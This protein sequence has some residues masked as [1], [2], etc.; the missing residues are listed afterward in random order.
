MD[1]ENDFQTRP[2]KWRVS[3]DNCYTNIISS[4]PLNS[5][6]LFILKLFN[7]VQHHLEDDRGH[8]SS[9]LH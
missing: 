3:L 9:T 6:A 5:P 4:E 2:C 8:L 1:L 7:L